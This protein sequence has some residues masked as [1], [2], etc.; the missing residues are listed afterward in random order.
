M[1]DTFR[2]NPNDPENYSSP[3]RRGRQGLNRAKASHRR[4][5]NDART[6]RRKIMRQVEDDV[7]YEAY[8]RNNVLS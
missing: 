6:I 1:S 4:S 7:S 3:D 2:F 8:V 5:R